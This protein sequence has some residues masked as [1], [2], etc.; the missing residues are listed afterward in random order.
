M[1]AHNP[2]VTISNRFVGHFRSSWAGNEPSAAPEILLTWSLEA[3]TNELILIL[4]SLNLCIMLS[5]CM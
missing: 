1:L 4:Q 3:V 5:T 2:C